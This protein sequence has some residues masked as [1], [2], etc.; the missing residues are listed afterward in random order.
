MIFDEESKPLRLIG[1]ITELSRYNKK[2]QAVS[3]EH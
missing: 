1:R 3:A 2:L